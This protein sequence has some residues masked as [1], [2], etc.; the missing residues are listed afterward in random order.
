MTSHSIP[1]FL[2]LNSERE[3]VNG[4]KINDGGSFGMF[5]GAVEKT[6]HLVKCV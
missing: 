4:N 5:H 3:Q 2:L 6:E 1:F